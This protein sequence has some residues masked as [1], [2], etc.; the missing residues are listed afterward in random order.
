MRSLGAVAEAISYS[1]AGEGTLSASAVKIAVCATYPLLSYA[2]VTIE[3]SPHHR[4]V[5]FYSCELH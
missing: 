5:A 3:L 2:L 4:E 1:L